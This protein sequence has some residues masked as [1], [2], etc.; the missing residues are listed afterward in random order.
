[1][2]EERESYTVNNG[3][4]EKDGITVGP[5][6]IMSQSPDDMAMPLESQYAIGDFELLEVLG[7]VCADESLLPAQS[8][9]S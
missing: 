1:M 5:Q 3:R 6:G 4:F 8:S 7:R 2:L 9:C